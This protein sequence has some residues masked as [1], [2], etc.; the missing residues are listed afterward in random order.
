MTQMTDTQ[1]AALIGVNNVG[2]GLALNLAA[3]PCGEAAVWR[4]TEGSKEPIQLLNAYWA[5][6]FGR[7]TGLNR[8]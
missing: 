4:L 7:E 2:T 8:I 6:R 1:M 5:N 3:C